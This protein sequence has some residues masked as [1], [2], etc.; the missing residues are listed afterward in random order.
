MRAG[1]SRGQTTQ[2]EIAANFAST[3]GGAMQIAALPLSGVD[4]KE[5][6]RFGGKAAGLAALVGAGLPVPS[7]MCLDVFAWELAWTRASL[8]GAEVSEDT[9]AEALQVHGLTAAERS[10]LID[11]ARKL[12]AH[13]AVRSSGVAED[14]AKHSFAGV[15]RS[16]VG[17]RPE[18]VPDAVCRVWASAVAARALGARGGLGVVVQAVVPADAAGV[19]FSVNPL[20]GSWAELV[21]EAVR[22]LGDSLMSGRVAGQRWVL[23]RPRLLP[24]GTL[25]AVSRLRLRVQQV[26]TPAQT[27]ALRLGPSGPHEVP[28]PVADQ[29]APVLSPREVRRLARLGLRAE[30]ALGAP[31]D[32]EW[33]RDGAGTLWLL[34]ARPITATATPQAEDAL[35]TRRFLGERFP[36][37]VSE[38]GWSVLRPVLEHFV[39]HPGTQ[40]RYL[41]AQ[42]ALRRVDGHVYV[43]ATIFAHLTFKLPGRPPPSFLLELL[44]PD[45]AASWRRRW[46]GWPS[47]RVVASYLSE[48]LR[49]RRW[50]R[51]A[52]NPLTNLRAWA[53]FDASL[54]QEL[55]WLSPPPRDADDALRQLAQLQGLL[56]GYVGVHVPSLLFANLWW[57]LLEAALHDALP[58]DGPRLFRAL[59][60]SPPGNATLRTHEA[61]ARVAAAAQP[62]D[63]DALAHGQPTSPAFADAL[64]AFLDAWGHRAGASWDPLAPRW[65]DAP[66]ALVG[67]LRALEGVDPAARARHQRDASDAARRELWRLA[68]AGRLP[69]IGTCLHF[70]RRY[71]LLREN[72]RASFERLMWPLR[73][74]LLYLG[75]HLVSRGLLAQRDD[76]SKL[77][78]ERVTAAVRG[79]L[80]AAALGAAVETWRPPAARPPTFL[81]G[82]EAAEPEPGDGVLRGLGVSEGRA[83]GCVRR[84]SGPGEGDRLVRGDVLVASAL[85]PG[86]TPLLLRAGAVVLELGSA[87]SHGAVIAREYGV[88]MVVNVDG[89]TERL[90]E[91]ARV[92][93]DGGRGLVRRV[94]GD[95]AGC[96][97]SGRAR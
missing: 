32:V 23:R 35:W 29:A 49:E 79:D 68:P 12:G 93:V 62:T 33:A 30:R 3:F 50:R 70:T 89:A 74:R 6:A 38:L 17:L 86:W 54:R 48:V 60:V 10:S 95:S 85:D 25:G 21:V 71:L 92:E 87:L 66:E 36:S 82:E 15:F 11:A 45:L 34:Q 1:V 81:R 24:R 27:T 96:G 55:R 59:A 31:V 83:S 84:I 78:L 5:V 75:D 67:L 53:T 73:E 2:A 13:L 51:F 90:A 61:L 97:A 41:D 88:P 20:N 44:P 14:G 43:N 77:S 80:G 46:A 39:D 63:L 26:D 56:Q 42:P 58:E 91:G 22:G 64:H 72:Q 18:D 4:A 19:L 65:R 16:E 69:W 57:Q 40:A 94:G 37:G 8:W 52:Y 9:A 76:V 47:V 7:A 28:V